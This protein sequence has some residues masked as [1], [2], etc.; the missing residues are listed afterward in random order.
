MSA[1]CSRKLHK[2]TYILVHLE[3]FS[4]ILVH[5][6]CS[7]VYSLFTESAHIYILTYMFAHIF[8]H[9]YTSEVFRRLLAV[10]EFCIY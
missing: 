5:L 2:C 6:K 7:D 4:H 10:N 1:R 9:A 8:T 3:I